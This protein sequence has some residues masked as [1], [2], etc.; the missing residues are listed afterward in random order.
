MVI[1]SNLVGRDIALA[2]LCCGL[3]GGRRKE[4]DKDFLMPTYLVH[5]PFYNICGPG[6]IRVHAAGY[7]GRTIVAP[8]ATELAG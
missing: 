3:D 8:P 5:V 1:F 4:G 6:A 2:I 7:H